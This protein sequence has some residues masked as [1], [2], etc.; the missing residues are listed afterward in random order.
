MAT[1]KKASIAS[2]LL[3]FVKQEFL[4]IIYVLLTTVNCIKLS[5]PYFN[6]LHFICHQISFSDF[7]SKNALK[8]CIHYK[9]RKKPGP[10]SSIR[11]VFAYKSSD[12]S[13]Y[14]GGTSFAPVA[15]KT[16]NLDFS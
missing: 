4:C 9:N 8:F 5:S 6:Q 14:L 11:R 10:A 12:L 1:F 15:E 16:R 3:I 7:Y 2:Q 13:L